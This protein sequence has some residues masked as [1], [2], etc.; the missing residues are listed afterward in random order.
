MRTRNSLAAFLV[1]AG[2]F[3]IAC[4]NDKK[5]APSGG[6]AKS[7]QGGIFAGGAGTG[8]G[9]AAG[10]AGRAVGGAPAAGA[11]AMGGAPT[12][13]S[14]A[15]GAAGALS[16]GAGG[17]A[18]G[19]LGG[20]AGGAGAPVLPSH[21]VYVGC[22]DGAGTLESY[23][24][25]NRLLSRLDT[26][27]TGGPISNA[28]LNAVEDRLHVAYT[29]A[30]GE[31]RVITYTRDTMTGSLTPL[32]TAQDVP[33]EEAGAG[34]AAGEGGAGGTAP[35]LT[36]DP[37]PQTLTLDVGEHHLAIPNHNAGNVHVY[38]VLPDGS[39][40]A[41]R[42]SHTGGLNAQHAVFSN[43]NNFMLVPYLGSNLINVYHFDD[44]TGQISL[45][46]VVDMPVAM[47]GPRHLALH[48]NGQWL[49]VINETAGGAEPEAGTL[50]FFTFDQVSGALTH[51]STYDVPLPDG[52]DGLKNGAEI[53]ISPTGASLY[54]SMRLDH[55]V[56]G[57]LVVY[58]IGSDGTLMLQQQES[59]R[60]VTPRHFSLSSDGKMLVVANQDSDGIVLMSMAK[61]TGRLNFLDDRDVCKSPRFARFANVK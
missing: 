16:A 23:L 11:T 20:M 40:G 49:Y 31:A 29:L 2:F 41:L 58:D 42:S 27:V 7:G 22:A 14:S 3:A 44:T 52:Y 21:H 36:L 32:G 6:G 51:V 59:V 45:S 12:A 33:Y 4:G 10:S 17:V 28:T 34:G 5:P 56:T 50:D 60:G 19:G 35:V 30:S 55:R 1:T 46:H 18:T 9:G 48:A 15:A 25:Q 53:A 37:G 57:E 54:V 39:V 61:N 47:S 24:V 43:D 26:V 38:E 13:G 8:S